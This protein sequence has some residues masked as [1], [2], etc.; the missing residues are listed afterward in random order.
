MNV[1]AA[2]IPPLTAPTRSNNDWLKTLCLIIFCIATVLTSHTLYAQ[3]SDAFSP[4]EAS[5]INLPQNNKQSLTSET[6]DSFQNTFTNPFAESTEEF[7]TVDEAYKLSI[8]ASGTSIIAEWVIEEKYFLYGEQFR[9]FI[10]GDKVDATR[11]AGEVSYDVIFEKDVEKYYTYT[12]AIINRSALPA[13]INDNNSIQLSVTYQGCADAGLCYPPET[14]N[15]SIQ[16]NQVS[17]IRVTLAHDGNSPQQ[18]TTS[19]NTQSTLSIT[20]LMLLLAIGGG[21][22]LNLMPC[23]FP[24]LSIKALSLASHTDTRSRIRHGWSYTL[25]CVLTFVVIAGLL[26]LIR[27]AGKAVGWGFQLQSPSVITFLAFLF[28][29]MGLC[30]SGRIQ[31]GG[32][33]M[34][35]GQSLTQGNSTSSSFFTGVLAAVV[36]SPC[37]APFMATA[38]GYALTQPTP[39]ALLIFAALGFGMALPFLFLSHLPQ[40]NRLLPKPGQWMETFKQAVAF[41]LYLTSI[42][43]LWV[44]GQQVGS[45]GIVLS[46][47]GVFAVLFSLWLSG[48]K[49]RL[50]SITVILSCIVIVAI[51]WQNNQKTGDEDDPQ[52]TN[53]HDLWEPYTSATLTQL[54]NNNATIFVNLTADWCITCKWNE[55]RVFTDETLQAMKD[56]GIYLLEGDWTRYNEEI[57]ALLDEYGRGGVPLYLLFKG[58]ELTPATVLPQILNP[59]DFKQLIEQL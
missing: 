58:D 26:L 45:D 59:N 1:T 22:I 39:I 4:S 50:K 6:S 55:K 51:I 3:Q 30:L 25:G 24:V 23:V 19:S 57:T 47:L 36:A 16:N 31:L 53:S 20:L 7:L 18:N 48:I 33:W 46:L 9:F 15:F 12:Q 49:P 43:L 11:P 34:G 40:L 14:K 42:W 21:A 54:R 13:T 8:R 17:E 5:S 2:P 28:F 37:T 41:P 29:I 56:K 44:L 10:N 38:L 35:I 52:A 27:D 32:S